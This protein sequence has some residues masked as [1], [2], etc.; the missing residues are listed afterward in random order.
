M[1]LDPSP[2]VPDDD[3]LEDIQG[4][5][6]CLCDVGL[7]LHRISAHV[8]MELAAPMPVDVSIKGVVSA[9]LQAAQFAAYT[10]FVLNTG[11][12]DPQQILPRDDK[13]YRAVIQV[14]TATGVWLGK[15]EQV[16]AT[17]KQGWL[18]TNAMQPLELRNEQ[19]LWMVGNGVPVNV[20]VVNERYA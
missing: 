11:N 20:M 17:L 19:G 13:R 9:Y 5:A 6:F 1:R 7:P 16:F 3:E 10:T 4:D 15:R 18:Q 8:P 2:D 12:E 14:S